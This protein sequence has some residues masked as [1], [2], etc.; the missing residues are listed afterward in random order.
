MN[1][2]PVTGYRLPV[3]GVIVNKLINWN[4]FRNGVVPLFWALPQTPVTLLFVHLALPRSF[5]SFG[6]AEL[7]SFVW[8]CRARHHAWHGSSVL[9]LAK[10]LSC[11]FFVRPK[12]ICSFFART[13]I[14]L[15]F[16][17]SSK[18]RTK[19]RAPERTTSTF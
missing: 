17:C 4:R 7:I 18:E 15:F 9:L 6:C 8:L 16:L 1:I 13:K 3:T 19:E 11:S 14:F 5:R 2:R 10:M 12:I